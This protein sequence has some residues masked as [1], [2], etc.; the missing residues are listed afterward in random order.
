M[1][2]KRKRKK[3]II[4][5]LKLD[6]AVIMNSIKNNSVFQNITNI[7]L[8]QS[9]LEV[10][11]NRYFIFENKVFDY[12]FA[13]MFFSQD[14]DNRQTKDPE[15]T[16]DKMIDNIINLCVEKISYVGTLLPIMMQYYMVDDM[17][18]LK[19][20]I[21]SRNLPDIIQY[22]HYINDHVDNI[23][24]EIFGRFSSIGESLYRKIIMKENSIYC[25]KILSMEYHERKSSLQRSVLVKLH[26]RINEMLKNFENKSY[27]VEIYGIIDNLLDLNLV[28]KLD[29]LIQGNKYAAMRSK[30]VDNPIHVR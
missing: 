24:N 17:E 9:T 4:N 25:R 27:S 19:R 28:D 20:Q 12:K 15:E 3:K 29:T 2:N 11:I 1:S 14:I 10:S 8:L 26:Y 7:F 21:M 30:N 22:F 6:N 13:K 5:S 23:N 18:T 16:M